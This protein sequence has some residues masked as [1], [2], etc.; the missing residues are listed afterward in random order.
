MR[1]NNFLCGWLFALALGTAIDGR[2]VSA[3]FICA[4]GFLAALLADD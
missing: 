4:L 2:F 1:F 3:G